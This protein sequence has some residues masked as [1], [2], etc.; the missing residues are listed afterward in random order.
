M[1]D[2]EFRWKLASDSVHLVL[3]WAACISLHSNR[4]Y[5]SA[6]TSVSG[7]KNRN[8]QVI[9]AD[10]CSLSK[11]GLLDC[12]SSRGRTETVFLYECRDD[13][14]THLKNWFFV[15]SKPERI[16]GHPAKGWPRPFVSWRSENITCLCS[17]SPWY[18]QVLETFKAV[19]VFRAQRTTY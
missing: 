16:R 14:T 4:R 12:G 9:L 2:D 6:L 15:T 7:R 13:V 17:P 10:A 1:N 11:E 3:W 19:S 18:G 8:N 5:G